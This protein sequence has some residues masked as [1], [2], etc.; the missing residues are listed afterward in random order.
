MDPVGSAG[1]YYLAPVKAGVTVALLVWLVY[2]IDLRETAGQWR[3][4]EWTYLILIGVLVFLACLVI[5]VSRWQ[6]ILKAQGIYPRFGHLAVIYIRGAFLGSFLPGGITTGD[7]YRMYALTKNTGDSAVSISSILIDRVLGLFALLTLSVGGLQ[8]SLFQTKNQAFQH[9]LKPV[10]LISGIFT[11]VIVVLLLCSRYCS[12]RTNWQYPF[13]EKI[14]SVLGTLPRYLAHKG[15]LLRVFL[16]SLALQLVIVG[17]TYVVSKALHISISL[18]ALFITVPLVSLFARLPISLGGFGVREA[19]YVLFLVPYGLTA[20]EAMSLGLISVLIQSG[21]R[22]L[23]GVT[24]IF[25]RSVPC[26]QPPHYRE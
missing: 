5:N 3:E 7:I 19:G 17:W 21:L 16:L 18:V 23:S 22:F 25:D 8:Y 9:L 14:V 15:V 12:Q 20:G 24:F 11:S 6:V 13:L 2:Q 26:A 4:T 1:R 10:I